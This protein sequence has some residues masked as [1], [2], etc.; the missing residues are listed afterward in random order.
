MLEHNLFGDQTSWSSKY[1]YDS[2]TQIC[3]FLY[4]LAR[5]FRLRLCSW[6]HTHTHTG[7]SLTHIIITGGKAWTHTHTLIIVLVSSWRSRECSFVC[8]E[9]SGGHLVKRRLGRTLT[10]SHAYFISWSCLSTF[11]RQ[12]LLL[13]VVRACWRRWWVDCV[14]SVM[15]WPHE[16]RHA[17]ALV[18]RKYL[19]LYARIHRNC[20]YCTRTLT[21]RARDSSCALRIDPAHRERVPT[22]ECYVWWG[23]TE[24]RNWVAS[25]WSTYAH[26]FIANSVRATLIVAFSNGSTTDK[27]VFQLGA[28]AYNTFATSRQQSRMC[29]RRSTPFT[30]KEW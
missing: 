14:R 15:Y 16:N 22:N 24:I 30:T 17:C 27:S 2:H 13:L 10:G 21:K 7:K 25:R 6:V 20:T 19:R 18:Q 11:T 26:G 1:K 8:K 9:H 29:C 12:H 5:E 3:E 23:L 28:C 4:Q